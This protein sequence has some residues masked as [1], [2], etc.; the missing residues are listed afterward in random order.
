MVKI[1]ELEKKW[2]YYKFKKFLVSA[3]GLSTMVLLIL[4]AYYFYITQ[5]NDSI[6]KKTMYMT[7][8]LGV[9]KVVEPKIEEINTTIVLAKTLPSK[10][11][12]EVA[13][14]PVIPVIDMVKEEAI[15][16]AVKPKV[17]RSNSLPVNQSNLVKAKPNSY[18]TARELSQI[19][20]VDTT[21]VSQPH[22]TKKMKFQTTSV[23]YIE[24]MQKKFSKSKN[25]RDAILI[26]KAFY[27][28]SNYS[29]SEEWALSANKLDKNLD[30]SW[31]LFAKSKAKLGKKQEAI[32]ILASY[33]KKSESAKA[34]VLIGQI[35]TG[36]I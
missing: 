1:N 21:Q 14:E 8:V 26:A 25:A 22:V 5:N 19:S 18:L 20:K 2:Y 33:Y 30:E 10:K 9:S 34:K 6:D 32:N 29:K 3:V 27:K 35:K 13:L 12:E 7:N 23:N 36:K 24:T 4:L 16:Y 15:K 31:L 28:K 11:I 17:K